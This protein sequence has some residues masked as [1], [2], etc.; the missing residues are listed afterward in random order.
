MAVSGV[1]SVVCLVQVACP[2]LRWLEEDEAAK[3]LGSA[4]TESGVCL[5][6]TCDTICL[7]TMLICVAFSRLLNNSDS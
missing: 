6:S 2:V 3:C 5:N 7:V 4:Q 1:I